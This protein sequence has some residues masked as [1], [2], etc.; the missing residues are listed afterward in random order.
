MNN[1]TKNAENVQKIK[2]LVLCYENF[3]KI[4]TEMMEMQWEIEK[5]LPTI[6]SKYVEE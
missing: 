1:A 5:Y 2:S 6:G 4:H 3:T